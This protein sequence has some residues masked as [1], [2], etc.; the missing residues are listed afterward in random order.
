[1]RAHDHQKVIQAYHLKKKKILSIVQLYL[2]LYIYI[3]HE[4]LYIHSS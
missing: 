2:W 3:P 1:M 4:W